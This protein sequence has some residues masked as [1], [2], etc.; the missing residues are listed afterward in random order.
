[1]IRKSSLLVAG[2]TFLLS[3][4]AFAR[5]ALPPLTAEQADKGEAL[6][7]AACAICHGTAMRGNFQTPPLRGTFVAR[8][9]NVP[10]SELSDY[11]QRAMPLMAPGTL[12]REDTIAITAWLLKANGVPVGKTPLP[13]DDKLLHSF[14]FPAIPAGSYKAVIPD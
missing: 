4:T 14:K 2:L 8:W 6:Y 13:S 7:G 11:I 5:A 1:M 10:V 12:S 3:G 9:A